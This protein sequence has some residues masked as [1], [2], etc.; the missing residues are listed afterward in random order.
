MQ[1]RRPHR[2]FYRALLIGTGVVFSSAVLV[3]YL[4]Y[5]AEKTHRSLGASV[6][7]GGHSVHVRDQGE[8]PCV[9]LLHGNGSMME[10]FVSTQLIDTLVSSLS[11]GP[12]LGSRREKLGHG[13]LNAKRNS[14]RRRCA[15]LTC[16]RLFWSLTPGQLLLR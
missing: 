11:I 2:A 13:A 14:S 3:R 8:G 4:T 5:R 15:F 7:V 1:T 6:N 12:A 9:V 10:D 16:A